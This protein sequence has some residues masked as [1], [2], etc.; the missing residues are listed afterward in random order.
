MQHNYSRTHAYKLHVRTA[1]QGLAQ[2][3]RGHLDN[4]HASG[5]QATGALTLTALR[6]VSRPR[7]EYHGCRRVLC[8]LAE[9][10][11]RHC[12]TSVVD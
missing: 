11:A 2:T 9:H 10:A 5:K 6:R 1:L 7:Q 4:R 8:L 12:A 3:L